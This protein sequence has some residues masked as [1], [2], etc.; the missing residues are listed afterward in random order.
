MVARESNAPKVVFLRVSEKVWEQQTQKKR[1][2]Y[3]MYKKVAS[4]K[5]MKVHKTSTI[6]KK[7]KS[8]NKGM[9]NKKISL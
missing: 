8:E 6:I 4:I 7:V 1:S 9:N 5:S 3:K 2:K